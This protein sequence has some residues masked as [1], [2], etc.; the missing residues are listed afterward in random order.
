MILMALVAPFDVAP[1]LRLGLEAFHLKIL[2]SLTDGGHLNMPKGV[3]LAKPCA[4]T[5]LTFVFS[6]QLFCGSPRPC[7]VGGGAG[8]DR[9]NT[10]AL[11][12]G[13]GGL[14][15]SHDSWDL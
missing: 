9:N 13:A 1:P 11:G 5:T 14:S 15:L 10:M 8:F 7:D 12:G 2:T 3:G 4:I 6:Y